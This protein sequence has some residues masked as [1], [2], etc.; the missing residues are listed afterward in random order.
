MSSV[1]D[2]APS[3][4]REFLEQLK[5]IGEPRSR[6]MI[7]MTPRSGSSYLC[8]VMTKTRR[9]GSPGEVLNPNFLPNILNAIPADNGDDYLRRVM[10]KRKTPNGLSGLKVSWFQFQ[11]FLPELRDLGYIKGC[12]F[13]YLR[14]RDVVMQAISLFKATET[15]VFHT[16]VDHDE[17]KI[18]ALQTLEYS[19]SGIEKWR[20]HILRQEKGW[21]N[22]F[23]E[24]RIFPLHV[25]YE[26]I[27]EDILQL[28]KRIATFVAVDPNN[29]H[30]PEQA[31]VFRKVRDRRNIE[32]AQR[33]SQELAERNEL[34]SGTFGAKA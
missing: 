27:E 24:N 17:G 31:S 34:L 4:S 26:D 18:D 16:N 1:F 20:Q 9:F 10:I 28:M 11:K 30:M 3:P 22:F 12:R 23:Y 14:R 2:K 5:K 29:V 7:A 25:F 21:E 32:W 6:Y 19:F 33:F 13:I 8:D 15:D